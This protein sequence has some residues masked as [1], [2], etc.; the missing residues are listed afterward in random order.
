[1]KPTGKN[2]SVPAVI[3]AKFENGKQVEAWP[4]LDT[5]EMFKQI[6]VNLASK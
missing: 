1:M 3:L 5:G 6:G 4:Y 2:F